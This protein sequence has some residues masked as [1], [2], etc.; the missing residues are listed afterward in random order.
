MK[1]SLPI[2]HLDQIVEILGVALG[3]QPLSEVPLQGR[4]QIVGH[5]GSESALAQLGLEAAIVFI[6]FL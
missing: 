6:P 5:L 4:M 3:S 2:Q 1:E